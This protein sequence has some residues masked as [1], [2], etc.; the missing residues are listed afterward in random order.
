MKRS[1]LFSSCLCLIVGLLIGS[2]LPMPWDKPSVPA[3]PVLSNSFSSSKPTVSNSIGTQTTPD[4]AA[5][6]TSDNFTLLNAACTVVQALRQ[7][8]YST[9]ASFVHPAKGVTFTP[10]ST[11]NP[12]S[13]RIFSQ[14]EIMNLTQDSTVYTWG[15]VDGRGS[16]IEM[17]IE[18]YFDRYVFNVD[19][20]QA[21]Q[22]GVDR[23]Q[24]HGNALENLREA[25]PQGHFVD[26]CFPKLDEANEGLDW[27]SLKLVFESQNSN[28]LL[29]GV[30][31]G[32]WTI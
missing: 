5:Q 23:I 12:D 9:V 14:E 17:T 1:L 10:Y 32:E 25:Y 7:Q 31:H 16:P 29:V 3:A 13:D 4:E 20:T 22:I 30:V 18:D 8:D 21:P 26:F 24:M 2:L 6:D 27:C 15:T 11:V 28:W 19:Y